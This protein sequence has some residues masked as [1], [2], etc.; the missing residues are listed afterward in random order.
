[1]T[2]EKNEGQG[3]NEE[4]TVTIDETS[5]F[6]GAVRYPCACAL[7]SGSML[8]IGGYENMNQKN[9]KSS[10]KV[11]FYNVSINQ[12][13]EMKPLPYEVSSACAI[14]A[15]GNDGRVIIVGGSNILIYTPFTKTIDHEIQ[16]LPCDIG[17]GCCIAFDDSNNLH[18]LGGSNKRK[19]HLV[20]NWATKQQDRKIVNIGKL[21]MQCYHSQ[22]CSYNNKLYLFGGYEGDDQ[23]ALWIYDI[24]QKTW[25]GG[26][27][28]PLNRSGSGGCHVINNNNDIILIGDRF[29]G[30]KADVILL[31]NIQQNKWRISNVKLKH[32]IGFHA[33]ILLKE[34][35]E[36]HGF[37]GYSGDKNVDTHF[38]VKQSQ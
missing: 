25:K 12:Y 18:I 37:S 27:N 17:S 1:M 19:Q 13:V 14:K 38:I 32:K 21:P 31:Y 16:Q 3:V 5:P 2:D 34:R 6:Y 29:G 22:I 4:L 23:N 26:E 15:P 33:S 10:S 8:I 7:D 20:M 35:K 30:D 36:I 24:I 28:I 9:G 11:W